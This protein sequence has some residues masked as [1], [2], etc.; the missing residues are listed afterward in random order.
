MSGFSSSA[1]AEDEVGEEGEE[2][3]LVGTQTHENLKAAFAEEAMANR[4]YLYFAAKADIEG[5][6]DVAAVFRSIAEGETGHA[7]GHLEFLEDVGDPVTGEPMGMTED[8]LEAAITSETHSY[9]DMY[10]SFAETARNEGFEDVAQ[11][12]DSLAKAEKNHAARFE[13]ALADLRA[14]GDLS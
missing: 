14:S 11:W 4:R 9:N 12:F 13:R 1:A 5:H 8:C 7:H 10:A 6:S 2:A 3:D